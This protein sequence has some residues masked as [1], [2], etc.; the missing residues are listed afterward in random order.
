MEKDYRESDAKLTYFEFCVSYAMNNGFPEYIK[1]KLLNTKWVEKWYNLL[2]SNYS[3]ISNYKTIE[4]NEALLAPYYANK[5]YS[6][7]RDS[8]Q[9]DIKLFQVNYSTGHI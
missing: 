1:N 6:F 7:N 3:I 4:L 8:F 9:D 5:M 2:I